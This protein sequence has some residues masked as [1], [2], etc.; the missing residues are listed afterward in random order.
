MLS[1]ER[2]NDALLALTRIYSTYYHYS[3][4]PMNK[5][6]DISQVCLHLARIKHYCGELDD[7][8]LFYREAIEK[9]EG[10]NAQKEIQAAINDIE[11]EQSA[12][13]Q[14]EPPMSRNHPIEEA[15]LEQE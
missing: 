7:A 14:Q 6:L 9:A 4:L 15:S 1:L 11:R 13:R 2:E 3:H 10:E 12:I 8:L 5:T